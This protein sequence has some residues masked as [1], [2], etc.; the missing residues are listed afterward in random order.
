MARGIEVW[1]K[2]RT[3]GANSD[4]PSV[5]G[6]LASGC[7]RGQPL[8]Q[9]P[10]AGVSRA[11]SGDADA[12]A[13]PR[14]PRPSPLVRTWTDPPFPKKSSQET[15]SAPPALRSLRPTEPGR[16]RSRSAERSKEITR[17]N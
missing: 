11:P 17:R 10:S 7:H 6:N 3:A 15:V 12:P 2:L 5:W 14:P 16:E 8:D 13:R 4:R 9:R 1:L